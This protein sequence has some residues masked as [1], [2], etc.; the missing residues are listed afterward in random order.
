VSGVPVF[1]TATDNANNTSTASVIISTTEAFPPD[2]ALTRGNFVHTEDV[3]GGAAYDIGRKLVFVT[4]PNLNEVRVYSSVDQHQVATIPVER[5]G[6]IDESADGSAVFVGGLGKVFTINPA[7]LQVAG[8]TRVQQK[9]SFPQTS[10]ALPVQLVTLSTGEVLILSYAG[11]NVLLWNPATASMQAKDP[12]S[13][14][15]TLLLTRSGDH[16]TVFVASAAPVSALSALYDANT[17]TYGPSLAL[18][19]ENNVALSPDGSRIVLVSTPANGVGGDL[20]VYDSSFNVLYSEPLSNV[21]VPAKAIYSLDGKS[22]YLFFQ[23]PGVGN[24]GVAYDAQSLLPQGVFSMAMQYQLT[25]ETPFAID[26]TGLIFGIG[27]GPGNSGL[28][29]M[30]ASHPGALLAGTPP[31]PGLAFPYVLNP[32]TGSLTQSIPSLLMGSGFD[33]TV[34]YGVYIGAPPGSPSTVK[35]TGVQI[36]AL[37]LAFTAPPG[38]AAGPA[39]VTLTRSDGWYQLIPDGISY[40]PVILATDPGAVLPSVTTIIDI[41]GYAFPPKSTTVTIGGKPTTVVSIQPLANNVDVMFPIETIQVQVPPGTP[42]PADLTVTTPWGSTTIPGGV[43]YLASGQIYPLTGALHSLVYDSQR[44][45]LYVSSTDHNRVEVFDLESRTYLAPISVGSGPTYLALTPDFAELAVL[46]SKDETVSVIGLSQGS[47]TGTYSVLTMQDKAGSAIA[48]MITAMKP[49]RILVNTTTGN[50]FYV[51][52]LNLDSGSL[53]CSGITGCDSSG[54]DINTGFVTYFMSS[55][56]DAGQIFMGDGFSQI[57]ILNVDQNSQV[58]TFGL[59]SQGPNASSSDGSVLATNLGAYSQQLVSLNYSGPDVFYFDA[60]VDEN[61][62]ETT[63]GEAL[64][65]SG[66]LL[67]VWHQDTIGV[68]YDDIDVFDV[69]KGRLALRLAAPEKHYTGEKSIALDQTGSQL[70][71]LTASGI[72]V[73]QLSEV[74]LSI[75]TLI[76]AAGT[77]GTHVTVRGSGFQNG[78]TLAFGTSVASAT[79]VDPMTLT[80]TVPNLSPGVAQVTVTNPNGAQYSFDAAF[81]VH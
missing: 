55:D 19:P 61:E 44:N 37:G 35:S 45:R 8:L 23:Q 4:I 64:N 29:V 10:V 15:S 47:V 36:V 80:A 9:F 77:V 2:T 54:F 24:V 68:P 12:P 7:S 63:S 18:L 75:A 78:T 50:E 27:G 41:Y 76:P 21:G 33:P 67:F 1:I 39:N 70:F 71:L 3:P 28:A 6:S 56:A 32:D 65:S 46:N 13:F 52:A 74:P 26:E 16:G 22:F 73:E 49:H 62:L 60:Y 14:T 72:S 81:T 38:I 40:N 59:R 48:V 42:G 53:S 69:H 66:S 58:T 79:F 5:P 20:Y 34:Q 11:G 30:D 31:A 17:K 57:G 51:H 43:Q 25:V